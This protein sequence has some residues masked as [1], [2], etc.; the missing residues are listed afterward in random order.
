MR[1]NWRASVNDVLDAAV[2]A[3]AGL[4]QLVGAE[5]LLAVAAVDQRIG[6]GG[7]VAARLPH[8]RRHE[9]GGV[10]TDDVVA[11]LHHGPPPGVLDVALE[12]HAERPVV[13]GGAEAAV[14]LAR[15]EDEAASLGEVD[16]A[17][18]LVV[19]GHTGRRS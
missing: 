10:E 12:E 14:D 6:E 5:A 15:G 11:Q 1:L 9:D 19:L 3:R 18:H 2:R 16:D 4:G 13:P 17:V 7:D 8:L